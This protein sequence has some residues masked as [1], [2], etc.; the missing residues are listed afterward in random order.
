[1]K[2]STSKCHDFVII[3][4]WDDCQGKLHNICLRSCKFPLLL[5]DTF[6]RQKTEDGRQNSENRSENPDLTSIFWLL[7]SVFCHYDSIPTYIPVSTDRAWLLDQAGETRLFA[8]ADV[9]RGD[10]YV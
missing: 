5:L 8:D 4:L 7:N 6:R 1:V 2:L 3:Y 10:E 9:G